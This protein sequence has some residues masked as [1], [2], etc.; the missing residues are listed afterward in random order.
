MDRLR[1]VEFMNDPRINEQH[2]APSEYPYMGI[3]QYPRTGT[4]R[5]PTTGYGW[6]M[7][8]GKIGAALRSHRLR[9]KKSQTEV[10]KAAGVSQSTLGRAELGEFKKLEAWMLRAA[11]YLGF[12]FDQEIVEPTDRGS[13]QMA[14]PPRPSIVVNAQNFPVYRASSTNGGNLVLSDEPIDYAPMPSFLANVKDAYGLLVADD[15]MRP[16]FRIGDTALVH[17]HLPPVPDEACVFRDAQTGGRAIV[18]TFIRETTTHWIVS[19]HNPKGQEK[20]PKSAW[21]L[22]HRAV[23]RYS[24]R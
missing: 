2:R 15:T 16:E 4:P 18:R 1:I 6:C 13:A 9:Q 23:G 22:C 8:P 10:A 3:R 5:L 21:P 20:L 24:R 11:S 14:S 12:E 7:N 19:R 17:P